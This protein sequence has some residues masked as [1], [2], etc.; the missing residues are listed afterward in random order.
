VSSIV[1][2]HKGRS[3]FGAQADIVRDDEVDAMM[4]RCCQHVTLLRVDQ[5]FVG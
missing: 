2:A 3:I 1:Y 4:Q 5:R